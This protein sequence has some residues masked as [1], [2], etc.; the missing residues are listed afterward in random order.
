MTSV[1]IVSYIAGLVAKCLFALTLVLPEMG[2]RSYRTLMIF[3]W[4]SCSGG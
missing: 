1:T 4:L 2:L 3:V